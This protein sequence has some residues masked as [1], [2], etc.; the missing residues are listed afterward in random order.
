MVRLL[1]LNWQK[2]ILRRA[3]VLLL[4][5]LPG[6]LLNYVLILGASHMLALGDFGIFY[7]A[8]A[9]VN[10]VSM[11]AVIVGCFFVLD[12]AEAGA[13]S[14]AAAAYGIHRRHLGLTARWGLYLSGLLAVGFAAVF[15]VFPVTAWPLFAMVV[16]TIYSSCFVECQ[17]SCLQGM[18]RFA[19]LGAVGF[20]WMAG[21]C[22]LGLAGIYA[23]GTAWGG[24]AGVALAGIAVFVFAEWALSREYP[25][26]PPAPAMDRAT[27]RRL[28]TFVAS[29]GLYPVAVYLDI[30]LGY[31]VLPG[32]ALGAYSASAV[33]PKALILVAAPIVQVMF[34][35][36]VTDRAR[37][38]SRRLS[39][40]KG[41]VFTAVFTAAAV[42]GL[43]TFD[44]LVC[45]GPI[46]V[47]NCVSG[48]LLPLGMSSIA[49]CLI[50]VLVLR[51][52]AEG[53]YWQSL[54]LLV[55]G[56]GFIAASLQGPQ[57]PESLAFNYALLT[58]LS[59]LGYAL[60]SLRPGPLI[61]SL[62]ARL[63]PEPGA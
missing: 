9:I 35:V 38:E 33:L 34:P 31:V 48:L 50:R 4:F 13:G 23:I 47:K 44:D 24:M 18:Q 62:R 52:L 3:S 12:V 57:S 63:R 45:G 39:T 8:I 21:R 22:L 16:I 29:Y 46:G 19:R 11:P 2:S 61:A 5:L 1:K 49:L 6:F 17:R 58:W 27:T 7:T 26:A 25:A 15:F 43:L 37:S 20:S 30:L 53:Y 41:L 60:A 59:L 54:L 14:G 42:A 40:S 56:A 28:L 51:K 10:L 55:P 36:L 32:E